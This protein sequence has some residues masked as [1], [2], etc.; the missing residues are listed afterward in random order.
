MKVLFSNSQISEKVE[1]LGKKIT[2]DYQ[3]SELFVIG[4]LKGGF[5]FVSDLVRHLDLP[6][7]IEFVRLSS[8]GSSDR[9][10]CEVKIFDETG[11]IVKGRHILIVDDIM[12]TGQSIVAFKKHLQAKGPASVKIC[13]MINKTCRRTQ[14]IEPDYYGFAI[15]DGFI[16][17]YGLD[18]A[19]SYRTLPDIYVLEPSDRR[20]NP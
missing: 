14:D 3:G 1:E 15:T 17:G 19:E 18:F 12:D 6:V 2:A 9:P 5:M 4:I 11:D 16:V 20:D 13:T 10:E 8:Y 7:R